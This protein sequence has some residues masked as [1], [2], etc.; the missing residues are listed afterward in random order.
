[1]KIEEKDRLSI[2]SG[3]RRAEIPEQ[4]I[5]AWESKE[6]VADAVEV[7]IQQEDKT[8]GDP[9]QQTV[10]VTNAGIGA[11]TRVGTLAGTWARIEQGGKK[12]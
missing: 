2:R 5:G 1:M 11:S 6:R 3:K 9:E 10:V 7:G 12:R 8:A 4:K